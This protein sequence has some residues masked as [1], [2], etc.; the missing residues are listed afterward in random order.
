MLV[1]AERKRKTLRNIDAQ[2]LLMVVLQNRTEMKCLAM[3]EKN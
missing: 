3:K 1:H 2:G